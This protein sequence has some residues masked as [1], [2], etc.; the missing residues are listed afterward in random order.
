MTP[1]EAQLSGSAPPAGGEFVHDAFVYS[2]PEEFLA[3]SLPF[4]EEGIALDEP[5]LAAPT[6]A[7]ERLLKEALGERAR[8]VVWAEEA[9]RHKPLGRLSIFV[10]WTEEQLERGATRVRLLG[11]PVWPEDST[12]G[13]AE[14]KRYE[15]YLN[16]ALAPYP[17]WLVCPYGAGELAEDIVADACRTHPVMGH[18]HE[19]RVS[20]DY[21]EPV[22]FARLLDR[23][24][25]LP[26]PPAD[27]AEESFD[28]PDAV[29]GF[30]VAQAELA[31]LDAEKIDDLKLAA[32]E[33]A[34]N[35]IRHAHSVASVR[36][37]LEGGAFVCDVR[38]SGTGLDDPFAG[39]SLPEPSNG[40]GWGLP[41][42]RQVSD[43]VEIRD[44]PSGA[45]VRLH[46]WL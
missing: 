46:F 4:I 8:H 38:D 20:P 19:R 36:T 18:G 23:E 28:A 11:E 15:S 29:R 34:A 12:G 33:V 41:I 10:Q 45:T 40:G 3:G 27:A 14:W 22:D 17:I 32:S 44:A 2:S 21:L 25:P 43:V 6:R 5:I 35:A 26:E 16:V 39:Y 30:V 1:L 42:A 24:V 31:G 9:D 13:V 7:N 37:W